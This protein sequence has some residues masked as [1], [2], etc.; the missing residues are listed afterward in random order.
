MNRV[1]ISLIIAIIIPLIGIGTAFSQGPEFRFNL[2]DLFPL[3]DFTLSAENTLHIEAIDKEG[4]IDK[5]IEGTYTFIING[6][7]EKLKFNKGVAD[8]KSNF[9]SSEVFYIKHERQLNTLRHLYYTIGDFAIKIPL[10]LF[11]LI[12][13][14]IILFAVFVKRLLFFLLLMAF[15]L[16]FIMQGLDLNS[17][18]S[19]V[20]ESFQYFKL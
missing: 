11:I 2:S 13:V 3:H 8:L 7:I 18:F 12:P 20:K 10:W 15:I 16:F 9:S 1:K 17:F 6:Y 4:N 19:L 14:L 5:S